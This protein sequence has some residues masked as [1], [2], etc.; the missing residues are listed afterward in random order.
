MENKSLTL[1]IETAVCGGSISLLDEDRELDFWIGSG[2]NSQAEI[3]LQAISEILDRNKQ[4]KIQI[5]NIIFS[6]GPG[7]ETGI[8]IGSAIALGLKRALKCEY[9]SV[10]ILKAMTADSK[11]ESEV[12]TAIP[13]GKNRVYRQSF[14]VKNNTVRQRNPPHLSTDAEFLCFFNQIKMKGVKFIL[15]KKVYDEFIEI[16]PNRQKFESDIVINAGENLAFYVGRS[17]KLV[18]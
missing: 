17:N 9:K 1:A 4:K 7:S 11:L 8:K 5:K 13:A 2:K 6:N 16:M 12:V 14:D 15:H 10:E 3:L 18:N